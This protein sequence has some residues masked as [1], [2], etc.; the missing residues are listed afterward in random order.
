DEL[1]PVPGW[2]GGAR[3]VGGAAARGGVG[4]ST[5]REGVLMIES[6]LIANRGEIARRVIRTARQ[7][8]VRTV[9]V[10]SA[11]DAELPFVA[12]ADQAVPLD[13]SHPG[14]VYRDAEALLAAAKATGA[15]EIGR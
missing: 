9:A 7:L 4:S 5:R 10:H 14:Q 8:G 13:G 1:H 2:G 11:A 12:E 3:A 15:Q 6:L